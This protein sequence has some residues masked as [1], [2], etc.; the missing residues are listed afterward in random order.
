MHLVEVDFF[1]TEPAQTR[2]AGS[3]DPVRGQSLAAWVGDGEAHLRREYDPFAV[4][5]Q[6]RREG[7]LGLTVAVNIG[8][9]DE[10]AAGAEEA[11]QHLVGLAG[12]GCAT[13]QHRAQAEPADGQRAQS[14]GLHTHSPPVLKHQHNDRSNG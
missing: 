13:H 4:P 8:G 6:P 10:R 11:I 2:V 12:G 5:D 14:S 1:H 7:P 9:V 3:S